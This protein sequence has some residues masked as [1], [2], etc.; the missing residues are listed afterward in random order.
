TKPQFFYDH[1]TKQALGFQNPF[2][3]KKAYL[4]EPKLYDVNVIK[5]TNAIVIRDFEETLTLAEESRSKMLLK[6]KDPKMS[7]KKVNTT[8]VDYANYVNSLE[9]TPSSRPTKVEVPK[10]LPKELPKV[11]MVNTSLKKLKHHLASFDVVVKE[12]TMTTAITEGTWGFEHTKSSF[13][14]E[15]IPFV[16]ALKDLFNSFNQI[17]VDE[18]SKV[19]HV[20]H[21]MEQAVKQHHVESKTFDVKMNKVLNE[22]ERLLEQE[23]SKDIVNIIM[24][25]S[26]NNAYE[27]VHECEKCLKL[28]TELQKDFIEREIYDKLFKRY[29]TLEKH[30][31][32]LEFVTQLNQEIFQRDKLFSQQSDPTFD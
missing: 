13:R 15:I 11:R 26:V 16:K 21:Q 25:S 28:E 30:C 23:I 19:Q 8:P 17:L 31:I 24:N 10:E 32:S 18:L 1:T 12:R 20:F 7:E 2:Y 6:Q 5:K 3:L 14:D 22:N 27:T 29:T 9:P 4:L